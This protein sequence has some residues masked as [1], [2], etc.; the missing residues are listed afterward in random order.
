MPSL[1]TDLPPESLIA[2]LRAAKRIAMATHVNPDGDGLGAQA[3]MA[4]ALESLG[5]E[6][7][8]VNQDQ[9]G[10]RYGFL[11]LESRYGAVGQ[12]DLGL[13]LDTSVKSRIGSAAEVLAKLPELA[14]IDHHA[15]SEPFG[16]QAWVLPHAAST[17]SMVAELIKALGVSLTPTMASAIYAA[18]AHD[19]GCF[20]YS[21][22]SAESFAL[23]SDL[24]AA[25][26]DTAE[27]NRQLFESR[28]AS[29]L[30]IW[31]LALSQLEFSND[32][33]STLVVVTRQMLSDCKASK[34]DTDGIVEAA[35]AIEGVEV[36]AMLREDS[37]T[38]VKLSSRSKR[39]LDVNAMCAEFGGGGHQRASGATM[40][41]SLAEAKK[42][43]QAA[44]DKATRE[45]PAASR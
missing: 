6:V 10:P 12:A 13:V 38:V 18:L 5:K 41:M 34:E 3:A 29:A 35:R 8:L 16:T 43:I 24:K 21:N 33:L 14:I 40:K 32:G 45:R 1:K 26:A 17:G 20:R 19:T 4:E 30:K 36:A 28:P 44:L 9:P 37:D 42:A 31:A 25:G 23:A 15:G 11:N 27:I 2:S 39:W 7:V 22:T